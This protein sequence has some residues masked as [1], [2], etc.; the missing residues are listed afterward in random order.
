MTALQQSFSMQQ[1]GQFLLEIEKH[2]GLLLEEEHV[3]G[4]SDDPDAAANAP[5]VIL[6]ETEPGKLLTSRIGYFLRP[7]KHDVTLED[8]QAYVA[9][10]DRYLKK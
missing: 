9:F 10:A 8:W 7:G 6:A 1:D 2:I 3:S 4:F 5:K